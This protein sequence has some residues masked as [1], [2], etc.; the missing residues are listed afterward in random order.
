M[1]SPSDEGSGSVLKE[2]LFNQ[3]Q[4]IVLG[5]VAAVSALT[6][7]PL[8][9]LLWLGGE[10]VLMPALDSVPAI[11]RLVHRRRR[12]NRRGEEEAKRSALIASLS[13]V[14]A[15]R[16]LALEHLCTLI[17]TNYQGLHGISQVYLTE[18]RQKLDLVLDGCLHR[19]VALQRYERLLAH[20]GAEQIK[21]EISAVE[22]ELKQPDLGERTEAALEKNLE[23]KRRLLEQVDDARDTMKALALELD[24]MGSLLEVLHQNSV[25]MRDPQAF[26]EELDTIV[27]QS[28]ASE[29]A[30][31]E[32]EAL[33]GAEATGW[34]SSTAG[35]GGRTN[36]S[37]TRDR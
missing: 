24:S 8:P 17:E 21:K 33:L 13:P 25:S 19:L 1:S 14:S 20:R 9:L 18:Q 28:E 31:R 12:A 22:Q 6:L 30:V 3:Y 10:C 11:R 23:L 32:M 26:S 4:G 16:F 5:G 7:S 15:K 34:A 35:P 27:K 36:R 37:R 29:R 2:L